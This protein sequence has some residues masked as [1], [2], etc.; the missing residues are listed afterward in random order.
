MRI[1]RFW[2]SRTAGPWRGSISAFDWV[3]QNL[4]GDDISVWFDGVGQW[5]HH[6]NSCKV[7]L[8]HQFADFLGEVLLPAVTQSA[9][10]LQNCHFATHIQFAGQSQSSSFDLPRQVS[11]RRLQEVRLQKGYSLEAIENN[12]VV[13]GVGG[14]VSCWDGIQQ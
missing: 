9:P 10:E 3:G 13:E 4:L 12:E 14:D 2:W 7:V 8:L 11:H 1:S 6:H 5:P